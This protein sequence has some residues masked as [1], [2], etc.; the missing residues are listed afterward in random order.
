MGLELTATDRKSVHEETDKHVVGLVFSW[1]VLCP[2]EHP[3]WLMYGHD[4]I[5]SY[6][7]F[8]DEI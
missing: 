6:F 1:D 2:A 7:V 3:V 8:T 4:V 5:S